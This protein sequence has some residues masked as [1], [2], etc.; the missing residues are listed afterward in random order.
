MPYKPRDWREA[1]RLQ[2]WALSQKGWTQRLIAEALG[3]TEG[4]VSKWFKR[5]RDEGGKR[6]L[7]TRQKAGRPPRLDP[8]Q[9]RALA[10][11]LDQGPLAFG[12][13]GEFWTAKRVAKVIRRTFRVSFHPGYVSRLVRTLG[14]SV[15]KPAQKASQRNN[16]RIAYWS[17]IT[18]PRLKKRRGEKD[19]PSSS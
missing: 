9:L 11:L 3:V 1:R 8:E 6:A 7:R 4:A 17:K 5:S 13:I 15:Q 2:A 16:R 18:W 10:A 12:F 14:F 19:A